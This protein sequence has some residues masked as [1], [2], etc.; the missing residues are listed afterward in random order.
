MKFK[1]DESMVGW[2]KG[3][4]DRFPFT[5]HITWGGELKNPFV[6]PA[7]FV[8]EGHV[9]W[10]GDIFYC[11]G[12][13]VIDYLAG[14]IRYELQWKDDDENKYYYYKGEKTN[15]RPWNLLWTH[16]TCFGVIHDSYLD[17][18]WT[19][20]TYFELSSIP[21]FLGSLRLEP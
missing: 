16:T 19:S 1:I 9:D 5:F 13:I 7:S 3:Y 20:V 21:K 10:D 6:G 11:Y 8:A 12:N 4:R 14:N 17:E 2:A 15:I 18:F